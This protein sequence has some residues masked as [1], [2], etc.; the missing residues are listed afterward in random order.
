MS[1]CREDRRA[2]VALSRMGEEPGMQA[3]ERALGYTFTDAALL[4]LALTHP[5]LK[6]QD[7]QRLEFLGDAVLEFLV[8][9]LLYRKYP[10]WQEGDMTARRAAL[11][12]EETLCL[13]ARQ[14]ALGQ[15]LMMGHGEEQTAGRDK[16]SILADTF[17][18]VLAALYLDGGMTAARTLVER[19]FAHEETL[20]A[21][22]DRDDKTRLQ[23]YTQAHGMELPAYQIVLE[24]GPPHDR[25]FTAE[26]SVLGQTCGT[27]TGNSKKAAEQAAA[28]QALARLSAREEGG[29]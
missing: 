29:A 3:V 13:L 25:Q 12:C 1:V 6:R 20:C 23:E 8:S 15:A 17:E 16:P 14:L 19:L 27:G 5:S 18:A 10:D 11:V 2:H 28:K 7:N 21:H 26:V 24:E 22:R 9:D 4:R